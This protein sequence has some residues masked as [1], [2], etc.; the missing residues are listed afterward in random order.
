[1]NSST[2]EQKVLRPY[3]MFLLAA[4]VFF[5]LAQTIFIVPDTEQA[6]ILRFDKP[7]RII[8]GNAVGK[9]TGNGLVVRIPFAERVVRLDRSILSAS[10]ENQ[11]IRSV[12][13]QGLI[14]NATAHFRITKPLLALQN[15]RDQ[16]E[17]SSRLGT[18]LGTALNLKLSSQSFASLLRIGP[19]S[20]L[21]AV[22]DHMSEDARALG[23]E[24]VDIQI[25]KVRLPSGALTE[26]A[27][28]RMNDAVLQTARQIADN[29][30]LEVRAIRNQANSEAGAIYAASFG[31]D[32]S[33][34]DF[35]RAMQSYRYTFRP[36]AKGAT[37]LI[38]SPG[39]DYLR[40]FRDAK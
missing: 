7:V 38:L 18:R 22:K 33:F 30:D 26:Q 3:A 25:E 16:Q 36:D 31:R 11:L 12:E 39:I 28:E 4:A 20:G 6:V 27:I 34:Y 21:A 29:T 23:A 37:T 17:L 9:P 5:V 8:N 13:Q 24:I 2:F 19:N 40:E 10:A 15:V 1:M 35:Y 14:V 32:P